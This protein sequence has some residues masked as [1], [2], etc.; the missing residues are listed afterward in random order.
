MSARRS[1]PDQLDFLD[2]EGARSLLDQLLADAKL[3]TSTGSYREL[4]DFVARL[5][6]FAPFNAMLLHIQKPGLT[7]AASAHDWAARFNRHIK[8]GA[9]PLLIMWPFGPV[10]LVYDVQDTDGPPLPDDVQTF[11]AHGDVDDLKLAEIERLLAKKGIQTHHIDAGDARAGAIAVLKRPA[12]PKQMTSYRM[13]LNRNHPAAT[14]FTTVAHELAHLFL[15]HLGAD[16]FLGAPAR[17][18]PDHAQREV[19]AESVAYLVCQ[20]N[21]VTA[22]SETY[23]RSFVDGAGNIDIYAIMRAAGQIEQ[24]LDLA[25]HTKFDPPRRRQAALQL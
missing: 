1:D 10:A 16:K 24:L 21:G 15:G 25:G 11:F 2:I 3:Y 14:R 22:K 8:S 5:R 4:I 13:T 7:Y 19:E 17:P 20:R 6:N 23:L 18:R 12:D 9:R